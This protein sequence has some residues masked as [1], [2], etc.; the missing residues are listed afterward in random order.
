[1]Q[2]DIRTAQEW[3]KQLR[4]GFLRLPQT[5]A[6]EVDSLHDLH[7]LLTRQ[8]FNPQ[9]FKYAPLFDTMEASVLSLEVLRVCPVSIFFSGLAET[10]SL[11]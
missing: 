9:I 1:M 7:V 3:C 4:V 10:V 2:P 6:A 8:Y 5:P 11:I